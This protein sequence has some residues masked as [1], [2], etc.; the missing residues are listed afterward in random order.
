MECTKPAI[1]GSETALHVVAGIGDVEAVTLL[2]ELGAKTNI[3]DSLGQ[4]PYHRAQL[5]NQIDVL[6]LVKTRN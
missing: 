2:L 6:A 1:A 5:M 3:K 4:M